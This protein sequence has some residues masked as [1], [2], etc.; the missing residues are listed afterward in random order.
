MFKNI[1]NLFS[2]KA[3]DKIPLDEPKDV[4][5]TTEEIQN[6][7]RISVIAYMSEIQKEI[8][9][10]QL[11]KEVEEEYRLLLR[12]N[13][14]NSVNIQ[15][16]SEIKKLI[17]ENNTIKNRNLQILKFM[18]EAYKLFGKTCTLIN[19]KDFEY[20][21]KK[22][23][24]VCGKL[25]DYTGI[26]PLENLK[27]INKVNNLF[28][29]V[30]DWEYKENTDDIESKLRYNSLFL[31]TNCLEYSS[32]VNSTRIYNNP[33]LHEHFNNLYKI[34]T[35]YEVNTLSREDLEILYRFPFT[36]KNMDS[37]LLK[38]VH[39]E[40][41]SVDLF[42]CAPAQEM[43]STIQFTD[44]RKAEDPFICSYTDLGIV[45]FTKWG[46]EANDEIFNKYEQLKTLIN[47]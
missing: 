18:E 11:P 39:S 44:K 20:L 16:I 2:N 46:N 35:V 4:L 10:K 22:Y 7:I 37:N 24:L 15:R 19:F 45:I 42:I 36:Y 29:K 30:H 25:E 34:S 28:K 12:L 47:K 3:L 1:F 14:K 41:S 9:F 13:F 17:D 5:Y 31:P 33:I 8:E 27:E 32:L 40:Y 26:I 6:A 21:L 23:N 43:K 38:Y